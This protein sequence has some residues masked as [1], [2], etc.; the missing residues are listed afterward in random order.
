MHFATDVMRAG[1]KLM[2]SEQR[3]RVML[4]MLVSMLLIAREHGFSPNIDF[5]RARS[6]S[7]GFERERQFSEC[8]SSTFI[9]P[10]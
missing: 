9:R 4:L 2:L 8:L 10:S 3:H 6:G 7:G 5:I 1:G